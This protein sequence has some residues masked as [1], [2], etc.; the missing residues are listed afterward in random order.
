MSILHIILAMIQFEIWSK[1]I[2][3]EYAV[4]HS[5]LNLTL[6]S[7]ESVYQPMKTPKQILVSWFGYRQ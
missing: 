4:I 1:F 6:R 3:V 7:D 2:I 5:P